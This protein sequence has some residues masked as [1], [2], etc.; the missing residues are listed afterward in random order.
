VNNME[1]LM[2]NLSNILY[3]IAIVLYI[4][5]FTFI[6]ADKVQE[7]RKSKSKRV[8]DTRSHHMLK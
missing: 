4:A 2:L 3:I 1:S 8:I 5:G 7:F 6:I